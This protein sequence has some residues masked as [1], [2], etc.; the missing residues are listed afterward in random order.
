MN[1][2]KDMLP[3]SEGTLPAKLLAFK[4][5]YV[6]ARIKFTLGGM[7]PAN[8]FVARFMVSML[9]NR[10]IELGRDPSIQLLFI[11]RTVNPPRSPIDGGSV[12]RIARVFNNS[13]CT[14]DE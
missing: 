2:N 1:F 13:L 9:V 7:E 8:L 11:C 10:P 12:P 5:I 14:R 6:I 4:P 3:I